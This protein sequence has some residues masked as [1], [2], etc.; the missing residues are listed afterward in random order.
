MSK[1]FFVILNT[2]NGSY[3]PL[4]GNDDDIAKFYTVEGA[5]AAGKNSVL[6]ECFGFEVFQIGCGE[7]VY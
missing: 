1:D 3:T 5:R 6:G 2:Q 7:Y 4:I